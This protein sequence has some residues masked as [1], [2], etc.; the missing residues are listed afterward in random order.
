[1]FRITGFV[2]ALCSE[3]D[4]RPLAFAR[5]Y[6]VRRVAWTCSLLCD[7]RSL[8]GLNDD[9]EKV[10]WLAWAHDLNRWPFAHNSE[11]GLFDQAADIPRYLADRD[12]AISDELTRDLQGIINKDHTQLSS[13]GRIV[14]LA[15]IITGFVE[16]PLW[17]VTAL[18]LR[19]SFIPDTIAEYLCLQ[20]KRR[21]LQQKLLD[22]NR[23]FDATRSVVPFEARFDSL[24]QETMEAFVSNHKLAEQIPLGEPL[25]ENWRLRVKEDFM[26][27]RIFH[28]NN[29]M[30]S[31]GPLL[32]SQLIEPLCLK[33]GDTAAQVLTAI[34]EPET[35]ATCV[36]LGVIDGAETDRF[37]PEL[38]Y[39]R[40]HEPERSFGTLGVV[41]LDMV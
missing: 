27:E 1:M 30:I 22:L 26:R 11:K 17:T 24:F 31:K 41:E 9:L 23:L 38:D 14:L 32:R 35:L 2:T 28:Y 10:R 6:H 25:F 4:Q 34:D 19:P 7:Q 37:L 21:E 16:D 18:D 5:F 12:I 13:E 8:L 33:L 39:V 3:T 36:R 40:V 15:D 20:L 29:E